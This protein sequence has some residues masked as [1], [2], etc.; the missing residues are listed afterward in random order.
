[1]LSAVFSLF[2]VFQYQIN[3][4]SKVQA[5]YYPFVGYGINY[6]NIEDNFVRLLPTSFY[7]KCHL[8][9]ALNQHYPQHYFILV[10]KCNNRRGSDS[11]HLS[12]FSQKEASICGHGN[13]QAESVDQTK[14]KSE[15]DDH[16]EWSSLI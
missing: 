9:T 6:C 12:E 15:Q 1:M 2:K 14:R 4:Y 5:P 3:M 7:I 13:S 10:Y 11:I 16:H 8:F